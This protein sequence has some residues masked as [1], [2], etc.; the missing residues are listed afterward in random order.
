[1]NPRTRAHT[2]LGKC[3]IQIH[4]TD[5]S[6][7]TRKLKVCCCDVLAWQERSRCPGSIIESAQAGMFGISFYLWDIL[8]G[9]PATLQMVHGKRKLSPVLCLHCTL[10]Y[11]SYRS[12]R[13]V[14]HSLT[15]RMQ[16]LEL[17]VQK[18][19]DRPRVGKSQGGLCQ[20]RRPGHGLAHSALV[21]AFRES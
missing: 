2:R 17:C 9:G 11:Y 19:V 13:L 8:P 18:R 7:I 12:E 4:N 14:K 15:V 10:D 5:V 16:A 1:M 3:D 20:H 6:D 21:F